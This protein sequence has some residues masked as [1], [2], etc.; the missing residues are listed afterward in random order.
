V[1][2]AF[3][4]HAGVCIFSFHARI[5]IE[6]ANRARNAFT[7]DDDDLLVKFIAKYRPE[8]AGRK[9]NAL[10]QMLTENVHFI[11]PVHIIDHINIIPFTG[12]TEMVLECPASV[13]VL[14]RAIYEKTRLV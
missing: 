8:V 9:G 4:P 1:I 12:R 3:K 6:F 2:F 5:D 14:A 11:Y 7:D 10:Y 13:A